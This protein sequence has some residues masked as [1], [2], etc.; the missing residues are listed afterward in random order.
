[1]PVAVDAVTAASTMHLDSGH[2]IFDNAFTIGSGANRALLM[3]MAMPSNDLPILTCTWGGVSLTQLAIASNGF[4][5][6]TYIYGLLNPASGANII[7]ATWTNNVACGACAISFT[8][9]EQS[10]LVAAFTGAQN[11]SGASGTLSTTVT[12]AVGDMVVATFGCPFVTLT[13]NNTVLANYLALSGFSGAQN[14]A[15]GAASV[16]MSAT[17]SGAQPWSESAINVHAAATPPGALMP[18]IWM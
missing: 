11:N 3:L 10:S 4:D 5:A 2:H 14:R 7:D 1:M 15:A 9:V 6:V 16:V 8:G 17:Q 13:P 12:S 18:Q